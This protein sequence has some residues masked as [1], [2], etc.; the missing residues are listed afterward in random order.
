MPSVWTP[1]R[2]TSQKPSEAPRTTRGG[3]ERPLVSNDRVSTKA[4]KTI[5]RQRLIT[6]T[7]GWIKSGLSHRLAEAPRMALQLRP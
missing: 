6:S 3:P 4:V 1:T 5:V 7:L 2:T